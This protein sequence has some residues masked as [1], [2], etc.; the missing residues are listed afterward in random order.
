MRFQK[1]TA[2]NGLKDEALPDSETHWRGTQDEAAACRK[3]LVGKGWRRKD[4]ETETV[5]VPTDKAGLLAWLNK[6]VR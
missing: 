5:E 2:K 6:N 1:V 3:E 4:I